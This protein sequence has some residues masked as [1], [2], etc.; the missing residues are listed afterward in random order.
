MEHKHL[1]FS[2]FFP[3]SAGVGWPKKGRAAVGLSMSQGVR[4]KL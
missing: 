1:K 4:K 2:A 3:F